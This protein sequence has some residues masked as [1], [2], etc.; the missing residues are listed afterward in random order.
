VALLNNLDKVD[1]LIWLG[2]VG[3][4]IFALVMA[5]WIVGIIVGRRVQL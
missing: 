3:I 1:S 5:V 2:T 4:A